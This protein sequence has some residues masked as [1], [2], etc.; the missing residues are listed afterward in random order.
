MRVAS[1][2]CRIVLEDRHAVSDLKHGDRADFVANGMDTLESTRNRSGPIRA[3]RRRCETAEMIRNAPLRERH[4]L[5]R[6]D[7]RLP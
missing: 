7:L 1:T 2:R 4:D 5:I 6:F 3:D